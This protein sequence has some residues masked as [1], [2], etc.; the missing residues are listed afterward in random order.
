M[1]IR[2]EYENRIADLQLEKTKAKIENDRLMKK[3]EE[4]TLRIL[5]L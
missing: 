5:N 1:I 2:E 3:L 4:T